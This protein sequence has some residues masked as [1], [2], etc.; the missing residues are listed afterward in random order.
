MANALTTAGRQ[1]APKAI[2]GTTLARAPRPK[3]NA[4]RKLCQ[5]S[6]ATIRDRPRRGPS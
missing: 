5:A 1:S 6:A 4:D 2:A 3:P